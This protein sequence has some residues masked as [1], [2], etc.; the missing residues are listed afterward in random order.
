M[1]FSQAR[2]DWHPGRVYIG[3]CTL[4]AF[5]L[6]CVYL[7]GDRQLAFD[8]FT[9]TLALSSADGTVGIVFPSQ[10]IHSLRV[11]FYFKISF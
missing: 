10:F 7:V 6:E 8:G 9:A 3:I 5:G 1:F 4:R 2:R 11:N